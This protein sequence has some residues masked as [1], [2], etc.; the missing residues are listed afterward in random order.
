[1]KVD[2]ANLEVKNNTSAQRFEVQLGD[3]VGVIHYLKEGSTYIFTHTEV[4]KEFGGQGIADRMA[5]VA[6]ETAKAEG[7]MVIPQCPFVKAYIQRHK[8]YGSL[9][10]E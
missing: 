6:L 9:V 2:T 7:A 4:P 5:Y 8:E 10:A 3:K 1:M